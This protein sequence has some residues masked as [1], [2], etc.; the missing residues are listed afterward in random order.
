MLQI[1]RPGLHL[2]VRG[3][4]VLVRL[5]DV[6]RLLQVLQQSPDPDV[7]RSPVCSPP[8][9][10]RLRAPARRLRVTLW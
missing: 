10:L 4:F 8:S 7:S 5:R 9:Q 6:M 1:P 3:L 2:G